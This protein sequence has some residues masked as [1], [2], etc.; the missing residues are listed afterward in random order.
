MLSLSVSGQSWLHKSPTPLKLIVLCVATFMLFS[1]QNWLDALLALVIVCGLYLSIGWS[2]AKI[3]IERLKPLIWM[4]L[5]IM[6]YHILTSRIEEGVVISLRL[7]AAIGLATLITMTTRLDA[8]MKVVDW[9][10]EPVYK[11]GLPR[12]TLGLASALVIRFTPVFIE[13]GTKLSDAWKMRST[14][15]PNH[16]LLVPLSLAVLDDADRVAEALKARGGLSN[17]KA[18]AES[19][20]SG[21]TKDQ[22]T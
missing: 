18:G 4:V 22:R 21:Q 2:F 11:L 8:M 14:K 5:V 19:S 12:R 3:G 20:K 15:R 9:L 16:R 10:A 17:I 6:L 7:C 13:R 1:L